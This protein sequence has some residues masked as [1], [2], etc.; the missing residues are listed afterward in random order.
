MVVHAA[1]VTPGPGPRDMGV[2]VALT[3]S[4]IA[5]LKMLPSPPRLTL[6]G[7]AAIYGRGAVS[8]RATRENDPMLPDG[9]YG[10]S[11]LSALELGREAHDRHGLDVQTGILFNLLGQGQPDHMVPQAFIAAAFR[12]SDTG[13]VRVGPVEAVRDFCD[14]DDAADALV[15]MARHG[16]AGAILNVATGRATRIADL[17]DRIAARLPMPWISDAPGAGGVPVCY[18]DPAK[19]HEATGWVPRHDL[20]AGIAR[21]ID[22]ARARA[23]LPEAR[24]IP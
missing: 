1:G 10:V 13:P 6:V 17:L 15:A 12:Q 23:P 5:A 11:K 16:P 2:N 24:T 20:D 4:W 14:I 18:G 9:A 19:L 21:A 3:R 7:S 22:A 8:D